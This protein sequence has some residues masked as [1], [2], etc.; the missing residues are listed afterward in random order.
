M[1]T[2]NI[3]LFVLIFAL[4]ATSASLIYEVGKITSEK[5]LDVIANPV[6]SISDTFAAATEGK[7]PEKISP[8]DHIKENQIKVYDDKIELDIKNAVWSRFA[9]T[10][11]MDPFF[12]QEANGIEIK[13]NSEDDIQI[14]DVISY[15]NGNDVI[16]HRVI[17]KDADENGTYFTVK[18]DNNPVQDPIK[19]RF[20]Q[21]KGIMV[22]VIY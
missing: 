17:K 8:A 12:D 7:A 10:N 3:L 14:G 22:G 5:P 19:L 20:S 9:D 6:Q 13:P 15:Q 11:S 16:I 18:G 4:G 21:I 1:E 2:R